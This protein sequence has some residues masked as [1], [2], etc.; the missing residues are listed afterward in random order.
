MNQRFELPRSETCFVCGFPAKNPS[1][2]EL[3]AYYHQGRIE[4][5]FIPKVEHIGFPG[6][7]HGGILVSALDEVSSWAASFAAD[8]FCVTRE[9]STKFFR[10]AAPGEPLYLS[11]SVAEKRKLILVEAEILSSAGEKIALSTGRFYP[12]LQ[13]EWDLW[14]PKIFP[15]KSE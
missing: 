13:K 1:S 10:Q 14:K 3:R 2:L 9:F 6:I 4:A 7:V 5:E 11:A 12:A 15:S 8:C